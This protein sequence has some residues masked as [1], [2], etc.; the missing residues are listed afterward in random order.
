MYGEKSMNFLKIFFG[1]S[2][3]FFIFFLGLSLPEKN[4]SEVL[5]YHPVR[6]SN[7]QVNIYNLLPFQK[8][9]VS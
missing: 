2:E 1:S 3:N 5:A 7:K 6:T 9:E 8:Y 4:R